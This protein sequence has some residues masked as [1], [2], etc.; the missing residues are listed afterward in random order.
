MCKKHFPNTH[1]QYS[2]FAYVKAWKDVDAAFEQRALCLAKES[3][4][5]GLGLLPDEQPAQRYMNAKKNLVIKNKQEILE[6][7]AH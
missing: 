2:R 5:S 3:K 6:S 1:G 7:S 4:L